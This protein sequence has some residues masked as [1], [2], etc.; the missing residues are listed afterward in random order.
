MAIIVP[1]RNYQ[2]SVKVRIAGRSL[3]PTAGTFVNLDSARVQR[4]ISRHASIG[5]IHD[6]GSHIE[7]ISDGYRDSGGTVAP[8][9]TGLVLDVA[10]VAWVN[11]AKVAG[12]QGTAGTA[13]VGA[14]DATNPRVDIV[15]VNT[16]T[17]AFSV[18]AGVATVRASLAN[19]VGFGLVGANLIPLA[20]VLVPATATNLTTANV[21]NI[22]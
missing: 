16:T 22:A 7:I 11:A 9:A 5:G 19:P 10:P 3:G 15:C 4:D 12:S 18:V 1:V 13:T 8:R 2:R 14:A 17:G 20:L 6:A 21:A